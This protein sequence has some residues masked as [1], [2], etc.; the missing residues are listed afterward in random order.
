MEKAQPENGYKQIDEHDGCHQ[1][2]DKEEYHYKWRTSRTTGSIHVTV[3]V[4]AIDVAYQ[5]TKC[6]L[7]HNVNCLELR[8]RNCDKFVT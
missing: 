2:V 6:V 4:A 1:N 3:V 8:L 7:I 5:R